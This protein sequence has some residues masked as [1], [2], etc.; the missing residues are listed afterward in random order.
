MRILVMNC[1]SSSL[2]ADIVLPENGQRAASLYVERIGT[3]SC[4]YR[5]GE[6]ELQPLGQVDHQQ[7]IQLLLKNFAKDIVVVYNYF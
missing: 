1:G 4:S 6:G 5:L 7:A 2:K 3:A